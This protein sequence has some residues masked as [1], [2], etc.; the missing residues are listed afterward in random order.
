MNAFSTTDRFISSLLWH[1]HKTRSLLQ[2]QPDKKR[3]GLCL[4]LYDTGDLVRRIVFFSDVTSVMTSLYK[5]CVDIITWALFV[6]QT[7]D[8]LRN[9]SD[10]LDVHYLT[11]GC[12]HK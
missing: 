4:F 2:S 12:L 5:R 7:Q 1:Q 10:K 11:W 8:Q 9:L 3:T 6:S